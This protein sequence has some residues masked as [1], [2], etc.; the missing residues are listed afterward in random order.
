MGPLPCAPVLALV[1]QSFLSS[2]HS[3]FGYWAPFLVLVGAG[4]GLPVPEE[5]TMVGSGYLVHKELVEF[6]PVVVV[7]W[8]ATLIGDSVPFW[9]GRLLGDKALNLPFSR[10]IL[11]PERF[12]LIQKRFERH[13][14]WAIF[15]CRF[16]PGLR[17]PGF[18][19]AGTMKM[20][21]PRFLLFDALGASVM[22]PIYVLVGRTFAEHIGKLEQGV[23]DST[24]WVGLALLIVTSFLIVSLLVRRRERQMARLPRAEEPSD[25]A[26]GATSASRSPAPGD[27][28]H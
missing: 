9:L 25:S 27:D 3:R 17:L 15:T 26:Q 8:V 4:C 12:A 14:N 24:H 19:G 7:C 5:V 21:Y 16:L 23:K 11:H 6:F 18:F 1:E 22:V 2:I 20:P 28:P 13:G 10:H